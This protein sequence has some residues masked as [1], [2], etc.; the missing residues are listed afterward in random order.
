VGEI[1]LRQVNILSA[2]Q[3]LWST[4]SVASRLSGFFASK[5]M[6]SRMHRLLPQ[7]RIAPFNHVNFTGDV[8]QLDEPVLD[9]LSVLETLR[10]QYASQVLQFPVSQIKQQDDYFLLQGP[11]MQTVKAE[12]VILTAG[13]GNDNLL[14]QLGLNMPLRQ[15]RPLQMPMLKAAHAQ[16]PMLYAHCLGASALPRM[17]ITSYRMNDEIIWYLG[18][19]IAEK[20]VARSRTEQITAAK[21][22][23]RNLLPWLDFSNVRWSTLDIDRAEPKMPDGGRPAEP[24]VSLSG[25]VIT[26]WPVKMAMTPLMVDEILAKLQQQK[27]EPKHQSRS[28]SL[29]CAETSLFPWEKVKHWQA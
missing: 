15:R 5:V 4:Q 13:A 1:D 16:L 27:T 2:H 25:K 12:W 17:T 14:A 3:Y 6:Q 9:S 7:Q 29:K 26:A 22:E 8:Y 18:G 10:Q 24:Y 19:D 20:G 28:L 11:D 23:L 21:T